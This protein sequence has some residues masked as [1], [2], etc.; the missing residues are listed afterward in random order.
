MNEINRYQDYEQETN[1]DAYAYEKRH[2]EEEKSY[3]RRIDDELER[4]YFK[5]DGY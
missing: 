1:R 5:H 3:R 2:Y 4:E